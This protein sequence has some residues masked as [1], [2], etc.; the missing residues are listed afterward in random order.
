M[1]K[2]ICDSETLNDEF[3][4]LIGKFKFFDWVVAWAGDVSSFSA[5]KLLLKYRDKIS[6]IVVGLH[7]YQTSPCFIEKF[8]KDDKVRFIK[9]TDGT[10]HPKL[11]LFHNGDGGEWSAI[12]GS[13]NLTDHGFNKNVEA[14]VLISSDDSSNMT[15]EEM[16]AFVINLWKQADPFNESELRNYKEC[17]DKQKRMTKALA[18]SR[19]KEK[20]GSWDTRSFD[21]KTWDEYEKE[22]KD[23][24]S[25]VQ[26]IRLL[27]NA[28][29]L[30]NV[31]YKSL[32]DADRKRLAGCPSMKENQISEDKSKSIDWNWFGHM[33][34]FGDFVHA[35]MV[36]DKHISD[37]IDS[38]P[39]TGNISKSTYLK[40]INEFKKALPRAQNSPL[41]LATRLLAIKR[42]D[43][44][45]CVDSRNKKALCK[46]FGITISKL[47]VDTYWD[48]LIQ[49]IQATPWYSD[50]SEES[51][52]YQY[53][54]AMLDC[55]HYNEEN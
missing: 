8:L 6:H 45:I 50:A 10:F 39:V 23:N 18:T 38:I 35:V 44:F 36:N 37:A 43:V 25:Y 4:R 54:V 48:L 55:L 15:F 12:I 28:R 32:S 24:Y 20:D 7:F 3:S 17:W 33:A 46:Q 2:F 9:K 1:P 11:Y 21:L 29:E 26:R 13:S 22:V 31:S 34:G 41:A 14:N 19:K 47:T 5:G 51:E 40:Y 27:E 30:F 16:K 53:R 42:P 49:R 52:L